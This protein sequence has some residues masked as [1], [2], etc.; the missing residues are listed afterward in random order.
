MRKKKITEIDTAAVSRIKENL[1]QSVDAKEQTL[2]LP[3]LEIKFFYIKSLVNMED[4]EKKLLK[5]FFEI[6]QLENYERYL[7]SLSGY[8]AYESEDQALNDLYTGSVLISTPALYL[9]ELKNFVNNQIMETNV[10]T[11][12]LGPQYAL[13]ETLENNLNLIR[14]RYQTP[15]LVVKNEGKYGQKANLTVMTLY[16]KKVVKKDALKKVEKELSTIKKS[17]IMF[18]SIGELSKLLS[19]GSKTLFPTLLITQRPDRVAHN[20]SEGKII[21]VMEGSPNALVCPAVF[22]DFLRSMDDYSHHFWISQ[23]LITLR[24]I[25]V[26]MSLLLPGIYIGIASYTP[27]VLRVQLA[28]TIAGSRM[29]VPYPTFIEVIFMLIMMELLTESSIRLPKVIGPTATTV[30]GLIL[31]QAATAAGLVSNIMIIIVSA[32]AIANFVIPINEMTF[33]F[34]VLKYFVLVVAIFSGLVGVTL[35]LLVILIWL[36]GKDSF[37]EP[38]LKISFRKGKQ[39]DIK[40]V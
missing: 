4:L 21:L 7:T 27:G 13:G 37:G 8:K 18:Q 15:N 20:L 5:P 33:S 2:S 17:E 16:D 6:N 11:T 12:I 24:F 10:E 22:F 39:K 38:Y 32:V 14:H 9:V 19:K 3:D 26:F 36:V 1:K 40:S 34:R 29:A 35:A 25:G 31:G 23:F 30:G 28:L